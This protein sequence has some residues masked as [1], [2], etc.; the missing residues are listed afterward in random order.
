[1]IARD[2][3]RKG[4]GKG[5]SFRFRHRVAPEDQPDQGVLSGVQGRG[6][7][8]WRTPAVSGSVLGPEP[9]PSMGPR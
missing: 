5:D 7:R 3:I 4:Q 1:M 6:T 9:W 2:G 8:P